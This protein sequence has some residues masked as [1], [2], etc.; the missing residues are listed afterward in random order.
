MLYKIGEPTQGLEGHTGRCGQASMRMRAHVLVAIGAA[1]LMI[2]IEGALTAQSDPDARPATF[3]QAQHL[4]Y[5]GRYQAAAALALE[6]RDPDGQDLA[7]YELRTSALLFQ[8]K[9]LLENQPDKDAAFKACESCP[10]LLADFLRDTASGQSLARAKL[11][12]APDDET[13][14]FLGKLDLNYVWL[15]L[16]P[17][18]KRTGWDEYWEARR[19]LDTVLEH[20]PRHVRAQVARAWIDYIVH[21]KAPGG[22]RWILGGGNKDR[23]LAALRQAV[24]TQA[25]F[26][27]NAEARFALWEMQVREK[28]V[29]EAVDV[30]RTLARDFPE[31]RQLA[32]FLEGR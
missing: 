29:D 11:K 16:D 31:N 15:H 25:D 12:I 1:G 20:N 2:L 30:A 23:A 18:G 17:L 19:S 27:A 28:R 4:F 13:L 8:L 3:K 9:R 32:T 14:F 22:T 5:N 6:L 7:T 10:A 21:T 24:D 26:F